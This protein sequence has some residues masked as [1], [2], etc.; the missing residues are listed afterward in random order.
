MKLRNFLLKKK[1][2]KKKKKYFIKKKKKKKKLQITKT[3]SRLSIL[4]AEGAKEIAKAYQYLTF[5]LHRITT[6]KLE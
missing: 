4:L 3:I 2:K 1:K 6:R 5:Y